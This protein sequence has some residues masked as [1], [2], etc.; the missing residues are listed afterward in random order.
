MA[1]FLLSAISVPLPALMLKKSKI[2]LVLSFCHLLDF[3]TTCC[4]LSS[5]AKSSFHRY[6]GRSRRTF[7]SF[8]VGIR[9]DTTQL[10]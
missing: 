6:D 8:E 1:L 10:F 4:P 9:Q 2:P 7:F 5:L 3:V